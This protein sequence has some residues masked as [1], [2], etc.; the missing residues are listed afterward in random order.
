MCGPPKKKQSCDPFK[1]GEDRHPSKETR[2]RQSN[3]IL[4]LAFEQSWITKKSPSLSMC[5]WSLWINDEW[6]RSLFEPFEPLISYQHG[7][8]II[9]LSVSQPIF[10]H[11]LGSPTS[12]F[13]ICLFAALCKMFSRWCS[14]CNVWFDAA[15]NQGLWV[16]S[17]ILIGKISYLVVII[18]V[19]AFGSIIISDHV[20]RWCTAIPELMNTALEKK[21]NHYCKR[22]DKVP[23]R[24]WWTLIPIEKRIHPPMF[25]M[26]CIMVLAWSQM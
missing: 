8:R 2:S 25:P 19:N 13:I 4:I 5:I 14:E 6:S 7:K 1:Q 12:T 21:A 22:H 17:L 11:Y 24:C 16:I 10:L 20:T 9:H 26:I 15:L 23:N 3:L 18:Q